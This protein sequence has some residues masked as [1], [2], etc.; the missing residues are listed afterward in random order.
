MEYIYEDNIVGHK[1]RMARSMH[2][3]PMEQKI[4]GQITG[5]RIEYHTAY[6]IQHRA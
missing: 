5:G 4:V 2:N 3:P 6:I 1:I